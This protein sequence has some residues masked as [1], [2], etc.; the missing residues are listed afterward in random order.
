MMQ[1]ALA[2]QRILIT[3]A[4]QQAEEMATLIKERG[5]SVLEIP[6]L[7]FKSVPI[8][9]SIES[10][11]EHLANYQWLVFT[12]TNAVRF[13]LKLISESNKSLPSH[14]KIAVVGKK[15]AEVV[16][17]Y[18]LPI[19][20]I[21]ETYTSIGLVKAFRELG[22]GPQVMLLPQG[23]LAKPALPNALEKD[24]HH[25]TTITV[26]ET[27]KHE[28]GRFELRHALKQHDFNVVTFA[29]PSAVQFFVESVRDL[30][31]RDL[32]RGVAVA[33]IGTVTAKEAEQQGLVVNII[34]NEFTAASLVEAMAL[35]FTSP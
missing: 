28:Q 23:Q 20:L 17:H 3:R 13:F 5:G 29:S 11:I 8:Q 10:P 25:V 24:G 30:N 6:V 32:M 21:P 22:V 15:T 19:H 12:S 1:G 9:S 18:Q 35:Y 31:W 16:Q 27:V 2:G 14:I 34:P 7:D 4:P 33:C 26:Y